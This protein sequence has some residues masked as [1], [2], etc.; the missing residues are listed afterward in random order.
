M[1]DQRNDAAVENGF[2]AL[3]QQRFQAAF[4]TFRQADER[5]PEDERVHMGLAIAARGLGDHAACLNAIDK[6]LN[7]NKTH[8]KA[9]IL[10]GDALKGCGEERRAIACYMA[11][12]QAVPPNTQLDQHTIGEL[13]RIQ[14]ECSSA[15][16]LYE[17]WLR[18]HISKD[19]GRDAIGPG[20]FGALTLDLVFG[21]A[22]IYT[23]Q[24]KRFYF[25][26]LPQRQFYD[27]REFEWVKLPVMI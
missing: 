13:Q 21:K 12:L 24:A 10:R 2:Q 19:L 7:N 8:L 17:S 3:Q 27:R 6:F 5:G 23:Q 11:A 25:P 26:E 9:L 4:E 14:R 16:G 15:M 20:T 18:N 22:Q 1:K